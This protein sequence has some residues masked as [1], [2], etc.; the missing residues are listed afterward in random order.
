M[1]LAE[2]RRVGVSPATGYR[3]GQGPAKD[4]PLGE[5]SLG[6]RFLR[7]SAYADDI[8]IL[9]DGA[10]TRGTY[11]TTYTDG[12]TAKIGPHISAAL[13]K[14]GTRVR[15]RWCQ[16][17]ARAAVRRSILSGFPA[18]AKA[19]AGPCRILN[20]E[21]PTGNIE[22]PTTTSIF[23]VQY[24]IFDIQQ[25]PTAPAFQRTGNDGDGRAIICLCL[26][27]P[28]SAARDHPDNP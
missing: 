7:F 20:I 14:P 24:S 28:Q 16:Q 17:A 10:V 26:R 2:A 15:V 23:L 22:L 11:V 21:Y 3:R 6:E 27:P 1:T 9:A 18:H 25:R 12:I 4:N 5:S 8:R 19:R 13:H